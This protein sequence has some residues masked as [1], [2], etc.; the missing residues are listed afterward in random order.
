MDMM[1]LSNGDNEFQFN[2]SMSFFMYVSIDELGGLLQYVNIPRVGLAT[3]VNNDYGL[4]INIGD[5]FI[6]VGG[7]NFKN[8]RSYSTNDSWIHVG[9]TYDREL[10]RYVL[11][12]IFTCFEIQLSSSMVIYTGYGLMA[13]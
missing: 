5:D 7:V 9:F 8:E 11:K 4:C 13:K 6:T 2:G 12:L 10:F 1:Q 3:D